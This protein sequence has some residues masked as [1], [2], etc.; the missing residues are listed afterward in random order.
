MWTSAGQECGPGEE[1]LRTTGRELMQIR[2]GPRL[3]TTTQYNQQYPQYG[4][5]AE[6]QID[7]SLFLFKSTNCGNPSISNRNTTLLSAHMIAN[8]SFIGFLHSE[9]ADASSMCNPYPVQI[10]IAVSLHLHEACNVKA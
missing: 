1:K 3:C 4:N 7:V 8:A 6:C 2:E 10:M 9:R 5:K